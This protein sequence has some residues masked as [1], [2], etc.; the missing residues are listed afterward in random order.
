VLD[1]VLVGGEA[2]IVRGAVAVGKATDAR[3][4]KMMGRGGHVQFD[5]RFVTAAD[6]SQLGVS[7]VRR[8]KGANSSGIVTTGIVV[9]AVLFFPAAPLL[10]L[11]HGKD[12]DI[13]TGTAFTLYTTEDVSVVGKIPPRAPVMVI[14]QEPPNEHVIEGYTLSGSG[15]PGTFTSL[16][17][18]TSVADAARIAKSKKAAEAA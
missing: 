16:D 7:G 4:K 15:A 11:K 2:A 17:A 10:F 5:A 9:S 8:V 6:G 14:A 18:E 3:G 1:D 13:P 12:T